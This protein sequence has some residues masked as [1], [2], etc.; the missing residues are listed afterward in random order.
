ML[1]NMEDP[2]APQNIV[3]QRSYRMLL[4]LACAMLVVGGLKLASELLVPVMVA[5]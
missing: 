2:E 1:E 4:A 5:I 3:S